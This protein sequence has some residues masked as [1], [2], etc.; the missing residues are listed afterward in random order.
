ML[1]RA[2]CQIA[3]QEARYANH[4]SNQL[5]IILSDMYFPFTLTGWL[6]GFC[7][8]NGQSQNWSYKLLFKLISEYVCTQKQESFKIITCINQASFLHYTKIIPLSV[9]SIKKNVKMLHFHFPHSLMV[10][11]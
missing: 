4:Y 6:I 10:C 9:F 5:F 8:L 7:S 3:P 1:V 2:E 11:Q